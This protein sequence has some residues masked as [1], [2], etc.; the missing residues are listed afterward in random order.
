[1]LRGVGVNAFVGIGAGGLLVVYAPNRAQ[2]RAARR[3]Y[4]ARFDGR[5]VVVTRAGKIIL[6]GA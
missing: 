3:A 5:E 4:G 6:G 2:E 1:M